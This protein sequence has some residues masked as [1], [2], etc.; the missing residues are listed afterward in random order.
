MSSFDDY[1]V[2]RNKVRKFQTFS[3]VLPCIEKLHE[4]SNNAVHENG[5]YTPWNLLYLI[6]ITF[7]EGGIN[8]NKVAT[9][10]DIQS[11]NPT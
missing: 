4:I 1:K 2:L 11:P 6:K 3:I 7:L 8:G 10:V 5:G 9:I